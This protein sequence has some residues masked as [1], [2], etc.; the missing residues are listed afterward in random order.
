MFWINSFIRPRCVVYIHCVMIQSFLL[1]NGCF[2][3]S[4]NYLNYRM[5]YGIPESDVLR[6]YEKQHICLAH[7]Y[8]KVE[9]WASRDSNI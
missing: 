8:F 6:E 9:I 5:W 4:L 2:T 3:G 1:F 7:A